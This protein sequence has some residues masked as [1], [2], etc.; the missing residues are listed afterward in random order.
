MRRSKSSLEGESH[1]ESF[2]SFLSS[3]KQHTHGNHISLIIEVYN[4]LRHNLFEHIFIC[5]SLN[6]S[7]PDIEEW[8]SSPLINVNIYRRPNC[9]SRYRH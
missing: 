5:Y 1:L 7:I 4:L 8:L 6:I 3:K 9:I 2:A